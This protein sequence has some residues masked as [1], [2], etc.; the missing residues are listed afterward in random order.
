MV[1][2]GAEIVVELAAQTQAL[3][4]CRIAALNIA[5]RVRS[6]VRS[7]VD[8]A[9]DRV[10]FYSGQTHM[11]AAQSV[12]LVVSRMGLAQSVRS[13]VFVERSCAADY[14]TAEA[15]IVVLETTQK[16]MAVS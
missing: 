2:V 10:G 13:S 6:L 8:V 11:Q 15:R 3:V 9:V 4:C 14:S 1:G 16:S 12:A 7:I 5:A